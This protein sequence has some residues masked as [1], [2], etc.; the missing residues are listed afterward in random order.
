MRSHKTLH[1]LMHKNIFGKHFTSI[2]KIFD[3][4]KVQEFHDKGFAVL[5]KVFSSSRIDE[6]KFEIEKII[7]STDPK[8]IKSTFTC[9]HNDSDKYFLE[10]GDKVNLGNNRNIFID[11]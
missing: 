9:D 1:K 2:E 3:Q 7:Q 10:S 4:K 5:P 11:R 8:E 6:L